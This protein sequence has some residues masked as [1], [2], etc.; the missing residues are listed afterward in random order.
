MRGVF[1]RGAAVVGCAW[2]LV[3]GAAGRADAQVGEGW[4]QYFPPSS[5]QLDG[6]NGI[7]SH[8]GTVTD[9]RNAGASYTSAGGIET[10][11]LFNPISNRAERRMRNN[12]RNGRWQF[13]G[14]VRV[15][16]PTDDESVTQVFGGTSGATTQMIRAYATD[17]GQLRKVPGSVV[18]ATQIWG[19]WI[20]INVVHDTIANN[21]KTYV[22]GKLA[23]TGDGEGPAEWYTKYGCYGTLRTPTAKV[24]WRNVKHFHDGTAPPADAGPPP[25]VD[26]ASADAGAPE[27]CAE[28]AAEKVAPVV[29]PPSPIGTGGAAGAP[30]TG[31]VVGAGGTEPA[32]TG[33]APRP[34]TGGRS[35]NPGPGTT[36]PP[37]AGGCQLAAG[38][39]PAG[40]GLLILVAAIARA[41]RSRWSRK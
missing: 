8:A 40:L 39:D 41:R 18:L 25:V 12:Y 36:P 34:G 14:E 6:A 19:K 27:V 37:P 1:S 5:I 28:A 30:G 29:E 9:V 31:G 35:S 23:T 20:R 33:G 32:G 2:A 7:E 22:D 16:P 21:V 4:K 17:G 26:A 11:S 15:S 13:E 24:E 38:A 3:V 10:F